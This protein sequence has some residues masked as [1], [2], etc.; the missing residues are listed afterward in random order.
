M[1]AALYEPTR[2]SHGREGFF[3]TENGEYK[4]YDVIKAV[5]E[6]LVKLGLAKDA[7]P[8][9]LTS[10]ECIQYFGSEFI[11]GVLFS[12]ARCTAD[13]LRKEVGWAPK[14][15]TADLIQNVKEDV[16]IVLAKPAHA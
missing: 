9:V 10:E 14:Y 8:D 5:G 16:E 11:A 1:N 12:N 4:V 15:T 2:I 3:F 6:T 7:E 13:R